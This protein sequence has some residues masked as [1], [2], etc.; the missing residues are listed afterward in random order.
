MAYGDDFTSPMQRRIASAAIIL[1]VLQLAYD[2][3]V[4]GM[5]AAAPNPRLTGTSIVLAAIIILNGALLF[6]HSRP[7]NHW[8]RVASWASIALMIAV[9]TALVLSA[10]YGFTT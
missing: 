8:L 2:W 10:V 9:P 3:L 1:A 7:A 6:G 5:M 4:A